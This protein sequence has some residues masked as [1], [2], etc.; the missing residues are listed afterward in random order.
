M[1]SASTGSNITTRNW[2]KSWKKKLKLKKDRIEIGKKNCLKKVEPVHAIY[3]TIFLCVYI[4]FFCNNKDSFKTFK[5]NYYYGPRAK[6]CKSELCQKIDKLNCKNYCEYFFN[7]LYIGQSFKSQLQQKKY[8]DSQ[9]WKYWNFFAIDFHCNF[10][11]F[12]MQL[13]FTW[14]TNV[15]SIVKIFSIFFAI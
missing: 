11:N 1:K 15:K 5:N 12:F 8:C 14:L 9:L 3:F 2:L 6:S 10:L 7:S 13:T 4:Y